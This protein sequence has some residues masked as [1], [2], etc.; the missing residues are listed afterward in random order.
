MIFVTSTKQVAIYCTSPERK[1][2]NILMLHDPPPRKDF[3][4]R[5][6]RETNIN[7][8]KQNDVIFPI[9]AVVGV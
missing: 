3:I 8:E 1:V 9:V 2:Y 4:K 7:I 5:E 6:E